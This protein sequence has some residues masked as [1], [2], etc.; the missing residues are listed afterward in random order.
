M[1]QLIEIWFGECHGNRSGLHSLGA[2]PLVVILHCLSET[3]NNS[4][5][6]EWGGLPIRHQ[7]SKITSSTSKPQS[8][9]RDSSKD[10]HHNVTYLGKEGSKQDLEK[11]CASGDGI[12]QVIWKE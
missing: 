1:T 10:C 5:T 9:P 3:Q 8:F 11:H 4:F 6:A 2:S 7:Y 12:G